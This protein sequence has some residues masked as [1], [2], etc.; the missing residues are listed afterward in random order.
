MQ[1]GNANDMIALLYWPKWSEAWKRGGVLKGYAFISL[2]YALAGGG[3]RCE[4]GKK[5]ATWVGG[6]GAFFSFFLGGDEGRIRVFVA[7]KL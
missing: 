6:I 3:V 4:E 7:I 2:A 5:K 1:R